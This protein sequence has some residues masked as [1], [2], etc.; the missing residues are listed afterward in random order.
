[1]V[2]GNSRNQ[3]QDS[4]VD[5][6]LNKKSIDIS[7]RAAVAAMARP[8]EQRLQG[9]VWLSPSLWSKLRLFVAVWLSP[10][11]CSRRHLTGAF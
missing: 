7:F 10:A 6:K 1:M 11:L 3:L 8:D 4:I 5:E 9:S 2:S